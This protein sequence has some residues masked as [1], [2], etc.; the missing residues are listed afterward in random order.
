[1]LFINKKSFC[2]GTC[3]VLSVCLA[4]LF[5]NAKIMPN[6]SNTLRIESENYQDYYDLTPQNQG[7]AYSND[8]VDIWEMK[9]ASNNHY[10]GGIRP[11]EWLTYSID[12]PEDGTYKIVSRVGSKNKENRKFTVSTDSEQLTTFNFDS[13]KGYWQNITSEEI[14]LSKGEQQLRLDMLTSGFSIDYFDLIPVSSS[15]SDNSASKAD[16]D[17]T[18][19]G[20]KGEYYG[21][22]DFTDLKLTRTDSSLDFD[23]GNDS[24]DSAIEVD[25][26]S[27][28]WSGQIEPRFSE[29]YK[30]YTTSDDGVRLW[31]NDQLII[32]KFV[33]R[34]ATE[35]TA[36]IE[37]VAGEKYDIRLEYYENQGNASASLAWS[38]DSQ[39][40]EIVP[41]SQLYSESI[42]SNDS[43]TTPVSKDNND[44]ESDVLPD[45]KP[46]QNSNELKSVKIGGGG[47]VTGIV[48]H[49]QT[50]EVMYARTDV[51]GLYRWDVADQDWH[52]LLSQE[53]VGQKVS[54]A[55]ESV[56]LDPSNPNIVYA[57][58]GAYTH[59]EP[60]NIL[61]SVDG[62]NTWQVLDISLPMGG[63][64]EWR[65]AGERLAVDP[66][67]NNT[68]YFG[69]RTDGLWRSQDGGQ[70]WNQV[71]TSKIPVGKSFGQENNQAGV[72]FVEFDP[73]SS[74]T[75][76]VGVAGQG[77]YQTTDGG[78]N[79]KSLEGIS[80]S[81]IPQQG[82]VNGDGELVVTLFDPEEGSSNGGIWSFNGSSWSDVTPK[83][84]KNY[85]GLTVSEGDP[86][87]LFSV[88][89]PMTPNDIYR[90]TDGGDTWTAL[91]NQQQGLDWYPDW[92]FW[93]LS[94]DLAVNP[95]NSNQVWLANGL[96]IWKTE[97]AQANK[98][99]WLA[100][101]DGIEETVPFDAVS[102]PGGASLI[103]AIADFDGF[104]H[105]DVE[106]TPSNNH[107]DG[108]F[109]TTTSISYSP[110]NP[111]FLVR[112][113]SNH[114]DYS[115]HSGFSLDNGVT[116]QKFASIKN[117]NH[118]SDLNFGNIAVSAN[119]TDN[120]VWQGSDWA[121]PYYTKDGGNSWNRIDYFEQFDGGAHTHL[122][123][124]QKALAA[125]SINDG[126]F[127]IYHHTGGQ[128]V[129]T[130][131]GGGS[132]TVANQD[133]LLP[134]GIWTGASVKTTPGKPG[135][136]WVSLDDKGLYRSTDA[137]ETFT[138]INGVEDAEAIG[139]GKAAPGKDNPTIF[140]SG[141]IKGQ[142]GVFGSTD[143]GNSWSR[144]N[145]LPN[146]FL[147]DVRSLTG[148]MNDFGKV[149]V[150]V[151]SIGFVYGQF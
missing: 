89:Y 60:G 50:A 149:Y 108:E 24:P 63:N 144:I 58:T 22:K 57:A 62:G 12:V 112:A 29:T 25:T 118:P 110:S 17:S 53:S 6:N 104:R 65:W 86:N 76:Y 126:T 74:G 99:N 116:W 143:M 47:F 131:D 128:L 31:V 11:S 68:V 140:V 14:E 5:S 81:L 137:G 141:E 148:D 2:L 98:S 87:T 138:Q 43:D 46:I 51:G 105:T 21:N 119:N 15:N 96:S 26:F 72:T 129:R 147:G 30:F 93:T 123:N 134:S 56:A 83:N 61:K 133:N 36:T 27:A 55:V 48:I 35:D 75:A 124:G 7:K 77:I 70:S 34:A 139:F 37:L 73:D 85:A 64:G 136:V 125:D 1:M 132:W 150:G 122:W 33:D 142:M 114:H 115:Q 69:S 102:T 66:H 80:Q 44:V 103:T 40:Y 23:W 95:T 16:S 9:S 18:G 130:R 28:R 109:T 3:F 135:D 100:K 41:Q 92:S 32:D 88:A 13:V 39:E 145:D 8:G 120:I 54:L 49:P 117:G 67:N 146:E 84:G 111:D 4:I 107:S 94:G 42:A 45:I 38:S 101:I 52:Q 113:S 82:E 20:L 79:W 151:A 10:V 91:N 106:E 71:D 97:E 127:Y 90:S 59:K 19:N 121:V 78:N